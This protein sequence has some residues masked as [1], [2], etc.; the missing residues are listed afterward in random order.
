VTFGKSWLTV[1][2]NA[3]IARHTADNG[4][5]LD[6]IDFSRHEFRLALGTQF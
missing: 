4:V 3:Q 5:A 2:W 6:L 1:G